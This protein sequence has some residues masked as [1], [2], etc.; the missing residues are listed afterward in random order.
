MDTL[1][2]NVEN[3]MS[4]IRTSVAEIADSEF[5][6]H[7]LHQAEDVASRGL[8]IAEKLLQLSQPP[9]SISMF[10]TVS[11]LAK[12]TNDDEVMRAS[13]NALIFMFVIAL[14]AHRVA[15]LEAEKT[16]APLSFS[17]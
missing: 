2:K 17:E 3:Y 11:L 4:D 12:C 16:Q 14:L 6:S 1:V 10:N 15:E 13:R 5:A 7:I 9:T 8:G